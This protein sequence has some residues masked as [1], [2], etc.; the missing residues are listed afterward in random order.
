MADEISEVR[1]RLRALEIEQKHS[2]E[3]QDRMATQVQEMHDLLM[4]AKGARWAIVGLASLGGFLSAKLSPF[5]PW[6]SNLPR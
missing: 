3:K 1:E 2:A 4:Q 6:F 5:I